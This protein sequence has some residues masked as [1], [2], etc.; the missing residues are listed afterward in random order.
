MAFSRRKKL[1]A[2][3]NFSDQT[4]ELGY[5]QI[6]GLIFTS[7]GSGVGFPGGDYVDPESKPGIAAVLHG[8]VAFSICGNAGINL[9]FGIAGARLDWKTPARCSAAV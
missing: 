2:A 7:T 5:C 8:V 4:V 3:E 1:L 9:A 6:P